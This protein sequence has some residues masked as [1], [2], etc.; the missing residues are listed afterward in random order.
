MNFSEAH[1]LIIRHEHLINTYYKGSRIADM[2]I[3]GNLNT[4]KEIQEMARLDNIPLG[5]TQL[6]RGE[7]YSVW[8]YNF[9]IG[10]FDGG[11]IE[12]VLHAR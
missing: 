6:L 11:P 9:D 1:L 4:R 7:T 5:Y 8:W 2:I 3:A 10:R 12:E